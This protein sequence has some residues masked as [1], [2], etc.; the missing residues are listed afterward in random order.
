MGSVHLLYCNRLFVTYLQC[1]F[2]KF[3]V[4]F[5]LKIKFG[6]L[7]EFF[8]LCEDGIERSVPHDHHFLSL[9]KP[10]DAKR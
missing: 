6:N 1:Q 5:F 4:S 7:K 2:W 8:Y 3:W 10:R 9:C